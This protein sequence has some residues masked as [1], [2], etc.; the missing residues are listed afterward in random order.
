ME[1]LLKKSLN[2]CEKIVVVS[3]NAKKYM[4]KYGSSVQNKTKVIYN[5]YDQDRFCDKAAGINNRT[6]VFLGA[7]DYWQNPERIAMAIKNYLSLFVDSYAKIYTYDKK[8]KI[9]KYL[10]P[11]LKKRVEFKKVLP[12]DVSNHLARAS[13]GVIFR[14]DNSSGNFRSSICAPIKFAEYLAAGLPVIVQTDIGDISA[15]VE[16]ENIGFIYN[17]QMHTMDDILSKM[18]KLINSDVDILRHRCRLIAK[19]YFSLDIAVNKYE[20][21]Y[22]DLVR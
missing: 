12:E 5:C 17:P 15:L 6:M 21:I 8:D 18:D 20:T 19:K 14:E 16:K 13:F 9:L 2:Y 1:Y 3:N 7:L 4:L 22:N 11:D 10:S